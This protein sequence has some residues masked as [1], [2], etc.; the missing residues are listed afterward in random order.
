[1][2]RLVAFAAAVTVGVA[3]AALAE[4]IKY[5]WHGYGINVP[6]SSK[7]GSYELNLSFYVENG[8][9]WGDWLQTGRVVRKFEFALAADGTFAG[10]VDLQ[11]SIM[12]VKG[13]VTVDGARMDMKGYCIFGGPLKRE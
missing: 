11:A 10:Q 6:Q 7:C 2:L 9:V 5:T 8:K 3:G 13:Q 4:P 12:N 1:M